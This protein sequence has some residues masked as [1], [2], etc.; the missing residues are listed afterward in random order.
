AQAPATWSVA[1]G[2]PDARHSDPR[3]LG[4]MQGTPPAPDKRV[5]FSDGSAM[6][7]PGVRWSTNHWRELY[8]TKNVSRGDGPV[9]AL[10]RAERRLDDLTFKTMTG[11]S[12]TFADAIDQM[13]TDRPI[14]L[15]QGRVGYETYRGQGAAHRPHVAFSITKSVVGT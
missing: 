9:L 15:H 8:P 7:F 4:I 12:T 3:A 10:P 14:V 13:Y 2:A 11:A 6:S 1:P 5:R